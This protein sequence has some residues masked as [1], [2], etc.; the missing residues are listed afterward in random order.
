MPGFGQS[1]AAKASMLNI[2]G[3]VVIYAQQFGVALARMKAGDY[4]MLAPTIECTLLAVLMSLPMMKA[5]VSKK[6][7]EL[8]GASQGKNTAA[9]MSFMTASSDAEAAVAHTT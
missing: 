7:L 1:W 8:L 2:C 4:C 9:A 5:A 6:E 3:E